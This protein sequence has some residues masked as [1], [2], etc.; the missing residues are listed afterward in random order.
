MDDNKVQEVN[1][2][3]KTSGLKEVSEYLRLRYIAARYRADNDR[4]CQTLN[5]L[6]PNGISD[7]DA[8]GLN[9]DEK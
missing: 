1:P 5:R 9:P 6:F 8:L 7:V 2:F 3:N 4:L